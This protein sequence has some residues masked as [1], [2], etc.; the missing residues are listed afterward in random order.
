M[1]DG[2]CHLKRALCIVGGMN[3][4]GAETF[5]MKVY[6]ALDKSRYQM[7]FYVF[8]SDE[9]FYD[10]EIISMGGRIYHSIPKSKKP[11]KSFINIIN[12][13]KQEKYEIVFRTSQHSLSALDLIAAKIGGAKVLVF[14]SS[15]SNTCS[16]KISQILHGIFRILL[17]NVPTIKI[18]PS[19]KAA[20]FMF[21]EK[22]VKNGDVII[23]KNA[24]P[25]DNYEFNIEK[26]NKIRKELNIEDKFVVGHVGRFN[27][28]KNH[29]F[30]IDIFLEIVKKKNNA[31]LVLVGKG[32]LENKIKSKIK[33]HNL[34]DKVIFTGVRQDVPDLLMA[35]DVFVFPS[36]FEGMPNAVIEAQATGLPCYISNSITKEVKITNLVH[37]IPL[38]AK[39]SEW[40]D[41]ILT[42]EGNKKRVSMKSEFIKSGYD[43]YSITRKFEDL[44]FKNEMP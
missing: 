38:D 41:I 23:V 6:R 3:A 10:K 8:T 5:L 16:G 21:G 34:I 31:V 42:N 1:H 33:E 26:R 40:A 44:I 43:I 2:N 27:E 25:I 9:G 13:V 39:A 32:E 17:K 37:F 19:T 22:C 35:M 11:F 7:D 24:I 28:Q 15:N 30:L 36:L 29:D 12:T 18:A 4:G 14:R 20:E